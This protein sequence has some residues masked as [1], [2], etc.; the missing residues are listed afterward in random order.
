MSSFSSL[1]GGA[2]GRG[3]G[4]AETMFKSQEDMQAAVHTLHKYGEL[5]TLGQWVAILGAD[6]NVAIFNGLGQCLG[7]HGNWFFGA[8]LERVA[9]AAQMVM[10]ED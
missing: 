8:K 6:E 1:S 7:N 9:D 2:G 4:R 3:R 10:R 5:P